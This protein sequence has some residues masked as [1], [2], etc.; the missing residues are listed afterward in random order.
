MD[1]VIWGYRQ[2]GAH[3]VKADNIVLVDNHDQTIPAGTIR[4]CGVVRDWRRE[5]VWWTNTRR[6]PRRRRA[7]FPEE[8]GA[9]ALG[10]AHP[11]ALPM[12]SG[13]N[14]PWTCAP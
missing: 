14:P 3:G 5:T 4:A 12:E 8:P 1:V 11:R 9:F 7:R 6:Q 13:T 2:Y 10:K